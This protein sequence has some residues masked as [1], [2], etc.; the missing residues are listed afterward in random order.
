MVL[1]TRIAH[2]SGLTAGGVRTRIATAKGGTAA[3][4]RCRIATATGRLAGMIVDAGLGG[5]VNPFDTVRLTAVSTSEGV[6]ADSW[7]WALESVASAYPVEHPVVEPTPQVVIVGASGPGRTF[8]APATMFGCFLTFR[9]TAHAAG[10]PD[11]SDTVTFR[12]LAHPYRWTQDTT[13]RWVPLLLNYQP[14]DVAP[15]TDPGPV[16]PGPHPAAVYP[17]SSLY[18]ST[19][20]YPT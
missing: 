17:G 13:G 14:A 5:Q 19:G 8:V 7:T 16:D 6:S 4:V 18:P 20:L 1:R 10:L 2:A 15:G 3:G 11:S 9:A 12:I